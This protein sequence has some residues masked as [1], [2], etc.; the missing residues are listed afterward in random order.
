M[1]HSLLLL[2][3]GLLPDFQARPGATP[4]Q[5]NPPLTLVRSCHHAWPENSQFDPRPAV[6]AYMFTIP[7]H[8]HRPRQSI[9]GDANAHQLL[10]QLAS[11]SFVRM[12]VWAFCQ[13]PRPLTSA[14]ALSKVAFHRL[15]PA[16]LPRT[17]SSSVHGPLTTT[18]QPSVLR[19]P[20]RSIPGGQGS[21][22]AD[23]TTD[24][25]SPRRRHQTRGLPGR[26]GFRGMPPRL[27]MSPHVRPARA[28]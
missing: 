6:L 19:P 11:G 12:A 26:V 14:P 27:L 22:N 17:P 8:L 24:A 5:P 3:Q 4:G 2:R 15:P 1:S 18:G 7:D 20:W 28:W 23:P 9:P 16:V 10:T 21:W 13:A 25:M